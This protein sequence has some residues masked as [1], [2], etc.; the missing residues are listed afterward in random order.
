MAI[1]LNFPVNHRWPGCEAVASG[2]MGFSELDF[3]CGEKN[4]E[5]YSGYQRLHLRGDLVDRDLVVLCSWVHEDL[6]RG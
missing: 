3:F 4:S 6:F 5:L 1:A 2:S